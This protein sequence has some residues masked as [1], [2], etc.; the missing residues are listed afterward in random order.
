MLLVAI[1]SLPPICSPTFSFMGGVG[2]MFSNENLNSAYIK[3]LTPPVLNTLH[4]NPNWNSNH[5]RWWALPWWI[6]E[7]ESAMSLWKLEHKKMQLSHIFNQLHW[8]SIIILLNAHS[9]LALVAFGC[10]ALISIRIYSDKQCHMPA[11]ASP[12]VF[13]MWAC[14]NISPIKSKV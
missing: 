7:V 8:R 12:M 2:K 6:L 14:Q 3:A 10:M 5:N 9:D 1:S 4:C 13:S 11:Q